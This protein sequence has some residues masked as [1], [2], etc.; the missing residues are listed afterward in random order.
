M[1]EPKLNI[2]ATKEWLDIVGDAA[3]RAGEDLSKYVRNAI[4]ARMR[5]ENASSWSP[6]VNDVVFR[7]A[8]GDIYFKLPEETMARFRVLSP[9]GDG[10]DPDVAKVS[11][12]KQAS[13][14]YE[15]EAVDAAV[16]T[17]LAP[18][19]PRVKEFSQ[20][21]EERAKKEAIAQKVAQIA[22]QKQAERDAKRAREAEKEKEREPEY[23][24]IKSYQQPT[25]V[26]ESYP[27]PEPGE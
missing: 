19:A 18:K 12:T 24:P 23:P 7:N 11:G 9:E 13:A 15:E 2:R 1:K 25:R 6:V 3:E 8:F 21:D 27:D 22:A 4:E 14:E 10:F 5:S 16:K 26:P 17:V 20:T